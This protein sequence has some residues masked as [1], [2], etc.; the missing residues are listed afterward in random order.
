MGLA[1]VSLGVFWPGG[2][3]FSTWLKP[4]IT[5][6]LLQ[7]FVNANIDYVN[8]IVEIEPITDPRI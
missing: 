2:A 8:Q 3:D 5:N 1:L 7:S 4:D 6:W